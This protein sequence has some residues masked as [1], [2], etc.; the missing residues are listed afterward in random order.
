MVCT[1][2]SVKYKETS[3]SVSSGKPVWHGMLTPNFSSLGT[4]HERADPFEFPC[5]VG[6]INRSSRV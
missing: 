5:M 3:L 6:Q 4:C 1:D 2:M